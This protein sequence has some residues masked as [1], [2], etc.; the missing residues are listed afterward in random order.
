MKYASVSNCK[1]IK[2]YKKIRKKK[3]VKDHITKTT[4]ILY[5]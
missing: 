2:A 3:D 5:K 1:E 4:I